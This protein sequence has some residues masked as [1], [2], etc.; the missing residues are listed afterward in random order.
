MSSP[1]ASRLAVPRQR[2][3]LHERVEHVG[4]DFRGAVVAGVDGEGLA[5]GDG[6]G[7]PY[8]AVARRREVGHVRPDAVVLRAAH[9][10]VVAEDVLHHQGE[11]V[12]MALG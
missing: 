5:P 7:G 6:A 3:G 4:G 11:V 10:G 2:A 9:A 1:S 12:R 8:R